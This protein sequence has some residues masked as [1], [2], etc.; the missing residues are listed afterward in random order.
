MV[1]NQSRMNGARGAVSYL[2]WTSGAE[3]GASNL[4]P[5]EAKISRP[6]EVNSKVSDPSHSDGVRTGYHI[7]SDRAGCQIRLLE[8]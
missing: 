4:F 2:S 6:S 3:G 8:A 1:I 5:V 7:S